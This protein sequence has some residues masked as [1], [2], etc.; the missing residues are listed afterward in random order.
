M[1]TKY[2]YIRV[3]SRTQENN[4]RLEIQKQKWLAAG[5]LEE[6]RVEDIKSGRTL[7]RP[8]LQGFIFKLS[9]GDVIVAVKMD[10]L[11]RT[12]K[13]TFALQALLEAKHCHLECLEE[14]VDYRNPASKLTFALLAAASEYEMD[15]RKERIKAGIAA[16]KAQN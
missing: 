5:I 14:K 1:I 8:G 16:K 13:Q 4:T 7:N 2:G 12:L 3:S 9:P 11:A 10:R 6:N 15:L